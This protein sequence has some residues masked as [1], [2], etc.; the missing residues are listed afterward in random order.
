MQ[1]RPLVWLALAAC[2]LTL[3]PRVL[4][5]AKPTEVIVH[6]A[7]AQF[8]RQ[9]NEYQ[10]RIRELN[11]SRR[12]SAAARKGMNDTIV[13]NHRVHLEAITRVRNESRT[14]LLNLRDVTTQERNAALR[15]LNSVY[16]TE[17]K[18]LREHE[19]QA[20]HRLREAG[21]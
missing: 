11:F 4:A 6:D 5:Q 19:T 13:N 16:T 7:E 21:R 20:L 8:R 9:V 15:S 2:T 18:T 12:P 1:I 10:A 17:V 14:K 3:S